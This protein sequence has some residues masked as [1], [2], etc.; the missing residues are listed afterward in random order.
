MSRG[1]GN[2]MSVEHVVTSMAASQA[3]FQRF[4]ATFE[5]EFQSERV[6]EDVR[7]MQRRAEISPDYDTGRGFQ[8][9]VWGIIAYSLRYGALASMFAELDT[10]DRDQILQQIGDFAA[11]VGDPDAG[12]QPRPLLL[13][14]YHGRTPALGRARCPECPCELP[15][16]YGHGWNDRDLANSLFFSRHLYPRRI[17]R[18]RTYC[19]NACRQRAYRRRQAEFRA[20]TQ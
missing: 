6:R 14:E 16:Q 19:S 15:V 10:D 4:T 18:W 12:I 3:F 11:Q 8:A 7:D 20:A 9:I 2:H 5:S 17:G 1:N 13:C